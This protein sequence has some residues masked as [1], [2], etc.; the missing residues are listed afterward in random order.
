MN[1]LLIPSFLQENT[2]RQARWEHLIRGTAL[3][4]DRYNRA[5]VETILDNTKRWLDEETRTQNVGTFTTYAF[6][7]IRRIFPSLIANELVS[8]QPIPQPTGMIFYLDFRYGNDKAP[9]VSGDRRDFPGGRPNPYFASGIVRGELIGTGDGNTQVFTLAYNPIFAGSLVVYVNSAIVANYALTT[10]NEQTAAITFAQAPAPGAAITVD[11]NFDTEA[12]G[13]DGKLVVPE[14][15]LAISSDSVTAETK[16]LKAKWSLEAQQDLMAYHGLDAEAELV[17]VLG[18]EVR[19]EIDR[20]IVNDLFNGASAG[21]V[22]WNSVRP[23]D[24]SG[25]QKEYDETLWHAIVDANTMVFKRRLRDTTWIVASPDICAR[26]EKLNGFKLETSPNSSDQSV[27]TG[28]QF[29]GTYRQRYRVYKDPMAVANRMLLGY[30][31]NSFFETGYVYAPYVP[32][33]TTPTIIDPNDFTPRRGVMS[34]YARKLVTG[35]YYST[36]TITNTP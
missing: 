8:T 29:I 9:T 22:N 19:R 7:L 17:N 31:G 21:N 32:L 2:A 12:M 20:L 28:L 6:P 13:K 27:Q 10:N 34:R 3:E 5:V 24:F 16:K 1:D 26:M 35:D 18:D 11:Y 23:A 15:D 30:K 33:Y 25:S 14:M 36:V 4:E